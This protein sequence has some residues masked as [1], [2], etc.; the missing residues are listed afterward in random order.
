MPITPSTAHRLRGARAEL[1]RLQIKRRVLDEQIAAASALVAELQAL[2]DAP[3]P[4]P[5][6]RSFT[7]AELAAA[8]R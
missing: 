3:P 7:R 2:A 8:K 1:A 5:P 4:T 6:P